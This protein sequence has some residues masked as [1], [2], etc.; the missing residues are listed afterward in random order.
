RIRG[1][2][3]H[4]SELD[5]L[6]EVIR[7]DPIAGLEKARDLLSVPPPEPCEHARLL[8]RLGTAYRLLAEF[9]RAEAAYG[10]ATDLCKCR[11]C[12]WDRLR[13]IAYL[14]AEQGEVA[15]AR[16]V[17]TR[18][19]EL[20]PDRDLAG[21]CRVAVA[22]VRLVERADR[23][24]INTARQ[25]LEDLAQSDLMY[26]G[27]AITTIGLCVVRIEPPPADLL[28]RT[29]EDLRALRRRWPRHRPY[30]APRAR[31]RVIIGM[32]G[33]RLGEIDACDFRD[34]LVRSQRTMV[35]L[36]MWREAVQL[37]AEAAEICAEMRREDLVARSIEKMLDA[38]PDSLPRHV[39]VAVRR[40][41]RSLWGVNRDEV[42]RAAAELRAAVT[43]RPSSAV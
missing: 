33:Y 19:V 36:G 41:R 26:V 18:A 11:R 43:A 12:R 42:L 35:E 40:F 21:R 20:A 38:L 15:T 5:R 3:A 10:E 13:R 30:R 6:D 32:I 22:Y 28:R 27:G 16:K 4:D 23:E 17:A 7:D 9:V 2:V 8:D 31:I 24:A 25:A 37:A 1:A 14:R 34:T 29:R 39:A